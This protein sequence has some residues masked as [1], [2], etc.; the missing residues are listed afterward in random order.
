MLSQVAG[1][2]K[3]YHAVSIRPANVSK[4]FKTAHLG[5]KGREKNLRCVPKPI[6]WAPALALV[7][8]S[9][10]CGGL[11]KNEQ[12]TGQ[13]PGDLIGGAYEIR[14]LAWNAG[15]YYFT[16]RSDRKA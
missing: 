13:D 11:S 4:L 10:I 9:N 1:G 15:E 7:A 5:K 16:Q 14:Y 6:L 8:S 3:T 12:T 2:V